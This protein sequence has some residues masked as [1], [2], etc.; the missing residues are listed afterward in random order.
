METRQYKFTTGKYNQ[1]VSEHNGKTALLDKHSAFTKE[2]SVGDVWECGVIYNSDA[3]DFCVIR[4]VKK[5]SGE[6]KTVPQ[7]VET[8]KFTPSKYQQAANNVL[9]DT[10]MNMVIEAVAGSGKST[11]IVNMIKS[12]PKTKAILLLAFNKDI[13]EELK[14]KIG[15]MI[16]VEVLTSHGYG[17]RALRHHFKTEISTT[18]YADII[19]SLAPKW[20]LAPD[21]NIDEYCG[22]VLKIANLARLNL[23]FDVESIAS[24]ANR[25]DI[26][27]TNG[28]CDH[29][30]NVMN[31]GLANTKIADYTDMICMPIVH[32]LKLQ[33][34]DYTFAD[35][36]QDFN[37]CQRTLMLRSLKQNIGRFIAVGDRKQAIYSFAGADAESFQKLCDLPNT[38]VLPLSV[39]YRCGRNIIE[40]AKTIVPQIE[41]KDDAIDGEI[42]RGASIND[43]KD[44]DMVLCR[45]TFPLVSLCLKYLSQGVKAHI[46]GKDIG[47]NLINMIKS[48]KQSNMENVQTKL[49][50]ELHKIKSKLMNKYR[51]SAAEAAAE[52]T[53]VSYQEK[54]EVIFLL[55]EGL[56]DAREVIE[57]IEKLFSDST[58]EGIILS[59]IHKSK[60]LEADR[61]FIIHEEL[62]PSKAAFGKDWAMEQEYNLIYV[63]YTRAL[64]YLG[65]VTDFNAYTNKKEK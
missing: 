23:I 25:Y 1:P 3:K 34:F 40:L 63:A 37:A 36:V 27:T 42:N 26:E 60:G 17:I 7:V 43:I 56:E 62:M 22:R 21:A 45:N 20:N 59:T 14:L 30:L 31:V 9:H 8:K 58:K 4:P 65:F 39:C 33:Q 52:S 50:V 19:K 51:M 32:K 16:N 2:V 28:E 47:I 41:A 38:K 24:M 18:K 5:I 57:K 6:T 61:V 54:I 49:M 12:L 10:T 35:E 44:G 48:T 13:V 46:K 11:T 64:K 15:N 29:A 55:A 53:Y